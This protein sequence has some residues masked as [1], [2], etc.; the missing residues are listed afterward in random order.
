MVEVNNKPFIWYQ[1]KL[2]SSL[3]LREIV[4]STGYL[5]EKITEYFKDGS[6]LD[7][8]IEYS[9]EEKPLGTGGALYRARHLLGDDFILLNGDDLPI[10]NWVELIKY[11]ENNKSFLTIFRSP[12]NGNLLVNEK[13]KIVTKY[14]GKDRTQN[15]DWVHAGL[16]YLKSDIFELFD[17]NT[18]NLEE[19]IYT[20]MA[21]NGQ[22]RYFKADD[23]TLSIGTFETLENTRLKLPNLMAKYLK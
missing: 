10:I 9:H 6:E 22:L 7:L 19:E 4:I 2:L 13:D 17:A 18:R 3:G 16:S 21:E 20:K 8:K 15:S 11:T 23:I 12:G 1:L 5:G 14:L